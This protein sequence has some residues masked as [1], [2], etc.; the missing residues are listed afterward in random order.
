MEQYMT[1]D[2]AGLR[3]R[4]HA[5]RDLHAE[6]RGRHGHQ[7]YLPAEAGAFQDAP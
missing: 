1:S 3:R 2:R 7:R 4:Y 6:P 5:H